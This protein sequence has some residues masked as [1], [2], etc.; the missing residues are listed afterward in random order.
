MSG[1]AL[2]HLRLAGPTRDAGLVIRCHRSL[3]PGDVIVPSPIAGTDVCPQ[4][5]AAPAVSEAGM[6]AAAEAQTARAAQMVRDAAE[7]A[8]PGFA[9]T[10]EQLSRITTS[11]VAALVEGLT[12]NDDR[13]RRSFTTTLAELAPSWSAV[14]RVAAC[15]HLVTTAGVDVAT[16]LPTDDRPAFALWVGAFA[17]DCVVALGYAERPVAVT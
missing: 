8:L 13:A 17:R 16:L 9:D 1:R 7:W 12:S 5:L 11:F 4:C 6:R 3:E 10:P 14:T 15:C 2:T